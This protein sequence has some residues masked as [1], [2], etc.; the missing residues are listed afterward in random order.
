MYHQI[1]KV[2][3]VVHGHISWQD[4]NVVVRS[5]FVCDDGGPW[6]DVLLDDR[7]QYMLTPVSNLH[8]ESPPRASLHPSKDPMPVH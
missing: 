4:T 1:D 3:A 6:E 2:L 5:P 8:H 7:E